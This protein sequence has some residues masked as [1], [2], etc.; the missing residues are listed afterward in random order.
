[1]PEPAQKFSD[2]TTIILAGGLGTRLRDSVP[3]R[4]KVLA[5][6]RGRPFLTYLFDQI[7]EAGTREVILCTGYLGEQIDNLFGDTYMSLKLTYSRE[8]EPLGTAG[9]L[10]L[11]LPLIKSNPVLIMNGDSIC[12][13]D[14]KDMLK[15]HDSKKSQA[16]I[17][18]TRVAEM[19]RYGQVQTDPVSSVVTRFEEKGS[20]S[21]SGWVNAGVYLLARKMIKEIP[22]GSFLSLEEQIFPSWIGRGLLGY[23]SGGPFLDIG[24]P[25][26][27]KRASEFLGD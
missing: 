22:A 20:A 11:A 18:L 15:W 10:R 17:L 1:M 6:V 9:A 19:S 5:E 26:S 24:T 12:L 16:T 4:P 23:Q 27:Y 13:T 2:L 3:D 25:E 7:Q 21:E 8:R 14:L